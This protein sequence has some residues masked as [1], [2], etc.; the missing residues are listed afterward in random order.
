[1]RYGSNKAGL[2]LYAKVGA[3]V[4]LLVNSRSELEGSP[5]ATRTYTTRSTDSPYRQVLTSVR[6]GAGVRYQ[7]VT[8]T[9]SLAVGPTAEA[10]LTTLNANPSQRAVNQSRP[11]SLGIEAS[12]EFG[13]PKP[14]PGVQQ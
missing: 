3:A 6:G 10:Y 12:V 4:S 13:S 11:Y 8:S 5:E 2:S 1:V 14:M 9:W 7:P